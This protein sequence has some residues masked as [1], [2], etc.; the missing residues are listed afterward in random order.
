MDYL[1]LPAKTTFI[2]LTL[3]PIILIINPFI[4]IIL[5]LISL[6]LSKLT[7]DNI[8]KY[9]ANGDYVSLVEM[10]RFI[11]NKDNLFIIIP[12]YILGYKLYS[13]KYKYNNEIFNCNLITKKKSFD[14]NI[15]I[16][17]IGLNV[18]IS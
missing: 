10:N 4:G 5:F 13:L 18:Y 17:P 6:Y 2:M 14:K 1:K 15:K 3:S 9:K 7:M 11:I 8:E 12:I 16:Y